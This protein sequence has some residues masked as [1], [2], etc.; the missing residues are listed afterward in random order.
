MGS[1]A[2]EFAVFF[3]D[4]K[5]TA[6]KKFSV[7][8]NK[9]KEAEEQGKRFGFVHDMIYSHVVLVKKLSEN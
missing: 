9:Q 8:K 2:K 7:I 1:H 5:G 4:G 3:K 6:S